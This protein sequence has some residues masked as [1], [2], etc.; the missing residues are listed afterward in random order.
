MNRRFTKS[1]A[2]ALCLVIAAVTLLTALSPPA[3]AGEMQ[4]L[5]WIMHWQVSEGDPEGT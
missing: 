5:G 1:I 3:P 2:C 4:C